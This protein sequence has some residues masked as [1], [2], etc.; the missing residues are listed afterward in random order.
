MTTRLYVGNLSPETV[1][2]DLHSLFGQVA[3]VIS[4]EVHT[5]RDSSWIPGS[6]V[7]EIETGNVENVISKLGISELDGRML[8]VQ[9]ARPQLPSVG[10]VPSR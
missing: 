1:A 2:E 3:K 6:G 5:R 9:V 4:V 10:S 7:V 8:R